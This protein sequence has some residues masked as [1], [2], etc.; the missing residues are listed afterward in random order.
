MI[1]TDLTPT[2]FFLLAITRLV[3]IGLYTLGN[4]AMTKSPSADLSLIYIGGKMGQSDT[5]HKFADKFLAIL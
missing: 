4:A 3:K 1:Q 2:Q 5:I